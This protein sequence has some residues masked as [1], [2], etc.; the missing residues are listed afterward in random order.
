MADNENVKASRK[1]SK[2]SEALSIYKDW[3]FVKWEHSNEPGTPHRYFQDV[4]TVRR[5]VNGLGGEQYYEQVVHRHANGLA[6]I[7]AGSTV[8]TALRNLNQDCD[9]VA[10]SS[11]VFHLNASD[12][13]ISVGSK[14]KK[15]RKMKSGQLQS[16]TVKPDDILATG[17]LSNGQSIELK[18]CVAGTLLETN[19]NLAATK[20]DLESQQ[21]CK[22]LLETDPL[23]DGYLA[24]ILP[25]GDFPG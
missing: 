2:N 20:D 24:I 8:P 17:L 1:R 10:I 6:I 15:A 14:R 4:Y 12:S 13:P 9:E 18:C 25:L 3:E 19:I 11:F 16:E 22:S 5:K 23:L 7:T 21:R